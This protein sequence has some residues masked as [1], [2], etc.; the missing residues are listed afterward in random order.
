[1]SFVKLF[2]IL[3]IFIIIL[4]LFIALKGLYA[5]LKAKENTKEI[6]MRFFKNII[7]GTLYALDVSSLF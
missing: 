4:N 6:T 2:F 3:I 7:F 1:M 5:D